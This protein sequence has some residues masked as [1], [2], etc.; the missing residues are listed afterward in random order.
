M[1]TSTQILLNLVLL[2]YPTL[3]STCVACWADAHITRSIINTCC[4]ILAHISLTCIKF[5]LTSNAI[6]IFR[7][8]AIETRA[9]ILTTTT[10]HTRTTYA[11]LWCCFTLFSVCTRWTPVEKTFSSIQLF[12]VLLQLKH[13]CIL[14]G[15]MLHEEKVYYMKI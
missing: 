11:A 4:S 8:S 9:K 13:V 12:L 5:I 14:T 3:T 15:K 2:H 7:T 1:H 10:M 6:I